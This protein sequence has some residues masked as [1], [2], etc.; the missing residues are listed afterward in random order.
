M[1][2]KKS[3]RPS[4]LWLA[5]ALL[6][7]GCATLE[8]SAD[9]NML[10]VAVNMPPN[11]N[12]ITEDNVSRALVDQVRAV[13]HEE[14]FK[15]PVEEARLSEPSDVSQLLTLNLMEWRLAPGGSIECTFS[16]NV[17]TPAGSQDLGMYT[18]RVPRWLGGLGRHGLAYSFDE[19]AKAAID[20][21]YRDLR[22]TDL[23]RTT[24]EDP[25][26]AAT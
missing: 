6:A 17:R 12:I 15:F 2:S 1:I 26:H 23:L 3:F 19:A 13:F 4:W 20:Q 21:L 25:V 16:A 22:K 5:A 11:F 14:G 24:Q 18:S 7:G 9:R 8:R 10:R